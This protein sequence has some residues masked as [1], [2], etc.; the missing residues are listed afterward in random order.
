MLHAPILSAGFA[1]AAVGDLD[2]D[3]RLEVVAS[4]NDLLDPFLSLHQVDHGLLLPATWQKTWTGRHGGIVFGRALPGPAG[5][6]ALGVEDVGGRETVRLLV[7]DSSGFSTASTIAEGGADE[8]L[9]AWFVGDLDSD[10]CE[11]IAVSRSLTAH[12]PGR[13]R[14]GEWLGIPQATPA[15][16]GFLGGTTHILPSRC[17][18]AP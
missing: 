2:L 18:R 14:L 4:G 3:G 5:A 7:V 15:Y 12:R 1:A 6:F 11:D 16:P 17:V 8:K 9:A 10:G 13:S